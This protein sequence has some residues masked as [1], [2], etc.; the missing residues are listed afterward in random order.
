MRLQFL[1]GI[2]YIFFRVLPRAYS[3]DRYTW[4][5]GRKTRASLLI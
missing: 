3:N 5:E 4:Y 2:S 1:N